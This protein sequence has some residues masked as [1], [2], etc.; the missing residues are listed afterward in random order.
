MIESPNSITY[1]T[2]GRLKIRLF[3]DDRVEEIP[4]TPAPFC[5]VPTKYDFNSSG[6]IERTTLQTIDTSESVKKVIFDKPSSVKFFRQIMEQRGVPVYEAD[7]IYT[8]R[9]M[10]ENDVRCGDYKNR[11]Y[12]DIENDD[13]HIPD[14]EK[15]DAPIISIAVYFNGKVHSWQGEEKQILVH[16]FSYIIENKISLLC[17]WN[18]DNWDVP[19]LKGRTYYHKIPF[20]FKQVRF[21]DLMNLYRY[22]TGS[23][24]YGL[25]KVS[26]ELMNSNKPSEGKKMHPLIGT[27]ELKERNEWDAIATGKVDEKYK[28]ANK[29]IAIAH[30]TYVF[31]DEVLGQNPATHNLTVTAVLDTMFLKQAKEKGYVLP[32]KQPQPRGAYKGALVYQRAWGTFNNIAQFDFNSLYP[33][34][35]IAFKLA[36]YGRTDVFLPIIERC[37]AG[38]ASAKDEYERWAYKIM[39]NAIYGIY[40]SKFYRFNA[41]PISEKVTEYGRNILI[42]I[43]DTLEKLG[44]QVLYQDTDSV[45]VPINGIEEV[46]SLQDTINAIVA[47]NWEVTNI[48]ISFKAL[49]RVINFPRNMV[50]EKTKKKYYGFASHDEK[51]QPLVKPELEVVGMETVRGDW[52]QFAKDIQQR[53]MVMRCSGASSEDITEYYTGEKD[54]LFKGVLDSKL[55]LSKNLSKDISEYKVNPPH[56]KA[57]KEAL[58]QNAVPI[59]MLEYHQIDYVITN[60]N[61]PR[62]ASLVQPKEIDYNFYWYRQAIPILYRLGAIDK[63]EKPP[64][65]KRTRKT[66]ATQT[67]LDVITP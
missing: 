44:Y 26:E 42:K 37:L 10:L 2:D 13:E 62:L 12:W 8:R 48:R 38:K 35:M 17:G 47:M 53:I 41:A 39:A 61:K 36:P 57:Y 46:D 50:G 49:W 21:L 22:V 65:K 30:M 56:V 16:F 20:D 15:P 29:A 63:I 54:K 67:A 1:V 66:K 27:L 51:K 28:L 34:I 5:Y 3:Y 43:Q 59:E 18:S 32:C 19:F 25:G 60:G 6:K 64:P 14:P 9:W 4:A 55:T 58:A 31:P 52:S 33:N 24:R 40:A 23:R 7:I 11:A 45:F